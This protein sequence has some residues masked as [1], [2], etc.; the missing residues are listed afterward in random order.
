MG[1]IL[2]KKAA[3]DI[4]SEFSLRYIIEYISWHQAFGLVD[5]LRSPTNGQVN[6]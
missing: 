3:W 1:P 5:V 6:A 2:L 4:G